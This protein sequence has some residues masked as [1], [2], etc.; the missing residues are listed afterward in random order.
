MGG[1]FSFILYRPG[2]LKSGQLITGQTGLIYKGKDGTGRIIKPDEYALKSEVEGVVGDMNNELVKYGKEKISEAITEK[3]VPTSTSD[4]FDQMAANIGAIKSEYNNGDL[5]IFCQTTKPSAQNGLWIKRN[6][7]EI[8]NILIKDDYYLQDGVAGRLPITFPT[9]NNNLPITICGIDDNDK[10]T[11]ASFRNTGSPG[12][13]SSGS[14]LLVDLN[15]NTATNISVKYFSG[16]GGTIQVYF[17]YDN[18]LF[19]TDT[20]SNYINNYDMI[21]YQ[22]PT[23]APANTVYNG[24]R[25]DNLGSA[26]KG[27]FLRAV[28][29]VDNILYGVVIYYNTSN[30]N[31]PTTAKFGSFDMSTLTK[32]GSL[33]GKYCTV[34]SQIDISQYN[35]SNAG[36]NSRI[37]SKLVYYANKLYYFENTNLFFSYDLSDNSLTPI[38]SSVLPTG[39]SIDQRPLAIGYLAGSVY[40]IGLNTSPAADSNITD[41]AIYNIPNN[42]CE[43]KKSVIP[44]DMMY[45]F[46]YPYYK[47]YGYCQKGN[48]IYIVGANHHDN[49]NSTT[50]YKNAVTKYSI[51]SNTFETGTILCQP[52]ATSNLTKMYSSGLITLSYGIDDVYYQAADGLHKQNAAIIKDGVVTDI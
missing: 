6:P 31:K 41:I 44:S 30:N 4:S 13:N 40:F 43:I 15:N 11:I 52:S 12:M 51:K 14:Q 2:F 18:H 38:N 19:Y 7:S 24:I 8:N 33:T 45:P 29:L 9:E 3:G 28:V 42:S 36:Y 16:F 32:S 35:L 50:K 49:I 37:N 46:I 20:S 34:L 48:D 21:N 25:F 22:G 26:E 23:N 39:Y 17:T 47:T 27:S 10:M 5:N 1:E